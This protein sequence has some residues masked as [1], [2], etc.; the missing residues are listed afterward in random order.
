MWSVRVTSPKV[1]DS[2]YK[3]WFAGFAF[4]WETPSVR[5]MGEATTAPAYPTL[6]LFYSLQLYIRRV[7]VR[8][9]LHNVVE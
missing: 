5:H 8:G 7:F 6:T 2:P 3:P 9:K 4:L 1:D